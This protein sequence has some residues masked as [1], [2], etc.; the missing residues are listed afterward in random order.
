MNQQD[1]ACGTRHWSEWKE[2]GVGRKQEEE[3]GRVVA[4][5][6]QKW[7]QVRAM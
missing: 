7:L 1:K 6:A 3:K 5:A 2:A 4:A